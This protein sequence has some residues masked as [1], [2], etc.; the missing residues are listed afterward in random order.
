[1]ETRPGASIAGSASRLLAT[2]I[3]ALVAFA[4]PDAALAQ[5]GVQLVPDAT[6]RL[7]SKDVGDERWAITLDVES[8]IV[9]G[10]VYR[11][12]GGDPQYVWCVPQD[13]SKDPMRLRCHGTG[14][15]DGWVD[16]GDVELPASF[17]RPSACEASSVAAAVDATGP[18][19]TSATTQGVSSGVRPALDAR[20]A[21]LADREGRRR[22]ALDDVLRPRH[23]DD[24]GQRLRSGRAGRRSS[25]RVGRSRGTPR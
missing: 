16:L 18:P 3:L 2:T 17:F 13:G 9:T 5:R 1:M 7:V 12:D 15:C 21:A 22:A 25:S 8:G 23:A 24:D 14:G 6:Q 11:K 19:A 10:N 4:R 20:R